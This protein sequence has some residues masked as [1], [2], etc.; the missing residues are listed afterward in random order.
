MTGRRDVRKSAPMIYLKTIAAGMAGAVAAAVLWIAAVLVVELA[1]PI[2]VARFS[3][4]SGGG[5]AASSIGSGSV[6]AAALVGFVAGS[7][8]Q[9]RKSLTARRS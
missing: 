9:Y 6:L 3:P 2:L 8:W 1:I 5:A 7:W 4:G